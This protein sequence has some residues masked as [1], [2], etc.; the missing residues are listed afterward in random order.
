MTKF[1]S[2]Y[3]F[4]L[5]VFCHFLF[6]FRVVACLVRD[7]Y[8]FKHDFIYICPKF[9]YV[10]VHLGEKYEV[11]KSSD[12]C[13]FS[14]QSLLSPTAFSYASQYIARYEEQGIGRLLTVKVGFCCSRLPYNSHTN[15]C[16]CSLHRSSV[17]KYV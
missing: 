1:F 13:L 4:P 10:K 2:S 17:G 15:K 7:L 14:S 5:L 6:S 11:F 9:K 3:N 8:I 16:T 12:C